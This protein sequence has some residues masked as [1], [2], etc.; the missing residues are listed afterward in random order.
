[1]AAEWLTPEYLRD[2]RCIGDQCEDTCCQRWDVHYDRK[3]YEVLIAAAGN[4][5]ELRDKIAMH[6]EIETALH[7]KPGNYALIKFGDSQY[8]PFLDTD[9]W[10]AIHRRLGVEALSN[11]CSFFP[12]VFTRHGSSVEMTGAL[13]CPEVVRRCF[14]AEWSQ[15][16]TPLDHNLLPRRDDIP[17]S[18]QLTSLVTDPYQ[19]GFTDVRQCLLDLMSRDDY[20]FETR[21]FFLANFTSRL[22]LNYRQDADCNP[23]VIHSE[24]ARM[25]HKQTLDVLEDFYNKYT[26]DEPIAIIVI[27]S[28]MHLVLQQAPHS[29]LARIIAAIVRDYGQPSTADDPLEVFADNVSPAKLWERFQREWEVLNSNWGIELETCL[30]RYVINCLQREWFTSMPDPFIYVHLLTIRVAVLK[31]LITMHQPVREFAQAHQ[32]VPDAERDQHLSELIALIVA[33]TYPFARDIDQNLVLLQVV[34]EA[35]AEQQMMS[36]EY[37]LPLIKY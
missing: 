8:C 3:H 11:T 7:R 14:A 16:W 37:S 30:T 20:A 26:N 29:G 28:I 34:Y 32:H 10:C 25:Q 4:A 19:L 27:Q 31:F 35:L 18:R 33:V 17:F 9:K 15:E 22:A 13:S 36:I 2:F 1:M 24:I 23:Q 12:R 5:P 6:L 21:Q